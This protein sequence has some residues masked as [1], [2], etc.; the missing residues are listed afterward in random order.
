MGNCGRWWVADNIFVLGVEV[1][2]LPVVTAP[3]NGAYAAI[4]YLRA[5]QRKLGCA[6]RIFSVVVDRVHTAY[7][8]CHCV[9][10]YIVSSTIVA[11]RFTLQL[12]AFVQLL[13]ARQRAT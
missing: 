6:L 11:V 4:T 1:P 8:R 10:C 5:R 12:I 2:L 9:P 7:F 13:L 3:L